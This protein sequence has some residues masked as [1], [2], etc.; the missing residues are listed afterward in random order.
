[1]TIF[2]GLYNRASTAPYFFENEYGAT[3]TINGEIYRPMIT[4]FFIPTLP[5]ND[6]NDV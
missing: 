1:M 2:Y 4:D 5:G 3:I 6:V